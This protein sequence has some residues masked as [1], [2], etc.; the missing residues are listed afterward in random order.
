VKILGGIPK[1]KHYM[2]FLLFIIPAL[3]FALIDYYI[4]FLSAVKLSLSDY[5]PLSKPKFIGLKN[6]RDMFKDEVFWISLK[7]TLL[8]ALYVIPATTILSFLIAVGLNRKSKVVSFLR[9]FYFLPM[10]TSSVAV[11]L[12]WRWIYN[13][14]YGLLNQV[15]GIFGVSPI[16]WLSD[17]KTALLAL[18]ILG[19]W[20]G[21]GYNVIIFL[22]GLQN[23]PKVYYEAARIDGAKDSQI[24]F[25]I[26]IPLM[27]PTIF[28]VLVMTTI[29]AFQIF[30]SVFVLT[31]GG[32]G[33]STYTLVYYIY[34]NGFYWFKMGYA[35]AISWFMYAFILTLTAVQ[36][37]LQRWW[38]HYES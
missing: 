14:D 20:G 24:L 10:V 3:A 22:A 19:I 16:H 26:T 1:K 15:L 9:V 7:N 36:F 23:I 8:Y 28:F 27:T 32:P 31:N 37:S 4:P 35:M 25:K 34:R 17:H 21:I 29:G 12:T 13:P 38:V 11:A 30:D 5:D 18:A 6:F 2:Y 33:Y